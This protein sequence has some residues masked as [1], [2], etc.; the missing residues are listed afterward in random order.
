MTQ[1]TGKTGQKSVCKGFLIS[2]KHRSKTDTPP[3]DD[4]SET[5]LHS[6]FLVS[7]YATFR[8]S[9]TLIKY[10]VRSDN[11]VMMARSFD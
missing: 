10:A 9:R 6:G 4:V 2:C 1:I 5:F 8:H 7:R 11:V 3:F